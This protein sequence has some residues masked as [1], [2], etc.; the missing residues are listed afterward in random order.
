MSRT[1]A[2]QHRPLHPE[3]LPCLPPLAGH[4]RRLLLWTRWAVLR[5]VQGWLCGHHGEAALPV[6][7]VCKHPLDVGNGRTSAL[8]RAVPVFLAGEGRTRPLTALLLSLVCRMFAKAAACTTCSW[9]RRC[10]PAPCCPLVALAAALGSASWP[11][12]QTAGC[13]S[14]TLPQVGRYSR[15]L[16]WPAESGT[17]AFSARQAWQASTPVMHGTA[18]SYRRPCRGGR[19]PVSRGRTDAAAAVRLALCRW[20]L[21]GSLRLGSPGAGEAEAR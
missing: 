18:C 5:S 12:E 7:S 19:Q 1:S 14:S 16:L 8:E 20:R 17:F 10:S 6:H 11:Q 4:G 15:L 3:P 9:S 21:A 13:T 2:P